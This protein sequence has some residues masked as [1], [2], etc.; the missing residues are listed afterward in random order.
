MPYKGGVQLLPE[1]Q[2][3]PTL[4]SY[5]S[6][7]SMFYG[8]VVIGIATIV[9]GAILGSY[10]ANLKDQISEIDGKMD[11][12]E[13]D[14]N[15][16]Q[17]KQIIAAAKQSSIMQQLLSSKL[18][19]TQAFKR[20]EQLTQSTITFT[21]LQADVARSRIT[22]NAT[23]DSYASVAR[24]IAAFVAATGIEDIEV[25][26]IKTTLQGK[27]EFSGVLT[28]DQKAMLNRITTSQ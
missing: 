6:G 18:Y 15:P 26:T 22:F 16:D 23:A 7:N 4:R 9:I 12:A 24:Q 19:W 27:V 8:A 1:T 25:G 28:I 20:M 17:E 5:T 10:K 14:R 21:S 11:V 13:Q 3:R 2:R